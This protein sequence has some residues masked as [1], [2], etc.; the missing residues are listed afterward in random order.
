MNRTEP[1]QRTARNRPV[2]RTVPSIM[3]C[4][5]LH[6]RGHAGE[7]RFSALSDPKC[8]KTCT[9][10]RPRPSTPNPACCFSEE[11]TEVGSLPTRQRQHMICIPL[12][13]RGR[14]GEYW[15]S[16]LSG[17]KMFQNLYSPASAAQHPQPCLF[18][19]RRSN[20]CRFPSHHTKTAHALYSPALPRAGVQVFSTFRP[21]MF[22]TL[23]SPASPAQHPQ[24]CLLLLRRSNASRFPSHHTKT[25][26]DLYLPCLA[27]GT[28]GSTGFQHFQ[29]PNVPKPLLPRFTGPA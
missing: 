11:A 5:P 17:P 6:Y 7:Y 23:Y 9:P 2:N 8:S 28:R 18:L 13:C 20:E 15:F 4:I 25:A 26:H 10:P 16:A 24:P 14:A 21:Q 27:A 1:L 19:L 22:Q 12:H 3:F 29:A